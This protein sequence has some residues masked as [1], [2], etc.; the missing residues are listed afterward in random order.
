MVNTQITSH[1][2]LLLRI[3]DLKAKKEV[4]EEEL[5]NTLNGLFSTLNL[6]SIFKGEPIKDEL[7]LGIVKLGMNKVIDLA[8]DLALGRHR[9]LKGFLSSILV[10]KYAN[11]LIDN[12][13]I[14][15]IS[16][17]SSMF[18]RHREKR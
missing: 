18:K 9:S 14:S 6:L 17:I 11:T 7:S 10:S 4:Q 2:E 16:F 5:K 3:S 15:V 8:I 13:L 12:N 1:S